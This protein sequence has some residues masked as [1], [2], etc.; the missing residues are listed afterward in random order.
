MKLSGPGRGHAHLLAAM[1]IPA[2]LAGARP[3]AAALV[4]LS[5]EELTQRSQVIVTGEV[6]EMR[7]YRA[8]F[9]GGGECIYTDVT[10]RVEGTLKGKQAATVTVQVLGGQIGEEWQVC[11][12]APRYRLGEKVLV[13]LRDDKGT[14]RNTGWIQGKYEVIAASGAVRGKRQLPIEADVPL[15]AIR[16]EVRRLDAAAPGGSGGGTSGGEERR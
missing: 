12:E 15:A 16:D 13:F 2:A 5:F 9:A 3:A 10:L 14:L 4:K 8:P 1:I 11:L 7:S 6:V